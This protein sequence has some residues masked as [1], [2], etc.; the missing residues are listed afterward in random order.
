M[1]AGG[2]ENACRPAAK[3]AKPVVA[4]EADGED[5]RSSEQAGVGGAVWTVTTL[6]AVDSNGRMFKYKRTPLVGVTF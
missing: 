3:I 6:A 5:Y 2:Q 1:R 4:F